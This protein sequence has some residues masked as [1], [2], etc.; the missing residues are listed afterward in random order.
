[1]S[2]L[3]TTFAGLALRNPLIAA[4]SGLTNTPEKVA[5]LAEAGIGAVVLKSIFEE[6]IMQ[7]TYHMGSS[8]YSEAADYLTSYVRSHALNE[9][10]RLIEE[11][12]K[13]VGIPVI[14]SINCYSPTEWVDYARTLAQAGADALEINILSVQTEKTYRAGT[15][16]QLHLDVL[17]N[18]K[19]AVPLPVIMK[20]GTNFTNPVSLIHQLYTHG[21][22]AVVLF[23][24]PYQPDIDVEKMVYTSGDVFSTRSELPSRIRWTGIT[25][26]QVPQLDI[27]VS[28]GIHQGEDIVKSILAGAAAVEVCSAL[29]QR[30]TP[31]IREALTTLGLW[32]DRKG[33]PTLASFK[34]LMN[35]QQAGGYT[36][37][38]RTQ[39]MKF[40]SSRED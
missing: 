25:S 4:S 2:K 30:S 26:L 36:N 35:A 12:K 5:L 11:S 15:Y 29:Y 17:D 38:E 33:Y 10:V 23:N 37:F 19:S 18:V 6:Q 8:G 40:F 13:R 20:L 7:E 31:F 22:A 24:R 1:M 9:Y 32:M 39:F 34:G 28:G 14:A 21:A 27:A 16:E 3:D